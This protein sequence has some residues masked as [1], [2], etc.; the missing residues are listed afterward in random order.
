[1]TTPDAEHEHDGEHE[2]EHEHEHDAHHDGD[3]VAVGIGGAIRAH[4]R[5]AGLSMRDLASR[6]GMSQPFLSNIENARATPSIATLYRL[7]AALGVS[8]QEF[9]PDR[10][11]ETMTLVRR[12]EGPAAPVGDEPGTAT[13]RLVAGGPGRILEA[14]TYLIEPGQ[15]PG[16]W[17]EHEGEDLLV[18]TSGELEV[19]FA[20]GRSVTIGPG[21]TLWHIGT[22]AH[23]WR[24]VGD[25]PVEALLVN[26]R[27]IAADRRDHTSP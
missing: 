25:D 6:A 15:T 8:P 11:D 24:P 4:R 1:M 12:G 22:I 10:A 13:S 5:R 16:D 3:T 9:L 7:G 18:V 2:R 23:R 21:D 19:E 26:G 14:H 27:H 17:F 20:D